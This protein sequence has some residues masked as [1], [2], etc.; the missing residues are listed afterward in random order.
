MTVEE[1]IKDYLDRVA[2]SIVDEQIQKGFFASGKSA[3]SLQPVVEGTKG[4]LYGDKSFYFQ[5]HG[6]GPGKL[7]PINEMIKYIAIK[8]LKMSPWALAVSLKN[9]G[10]AVW[11][12]ERKG[13]D[14]KTQVDKHRKTLLKNLGKAYKET[15]LTQI[16]T[17]KQ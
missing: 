13:L 10:S 5:V 17:A 3:D 8:R 7:P 4:T 12:R 11:R 15:L 14:I 2:T 6:R 16:K 9:K 1:A